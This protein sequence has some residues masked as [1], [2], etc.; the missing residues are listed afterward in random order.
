MNTTTEKAMP[1]RQVQQ[2]IMKQKS[3]VK[4]VR[5]A[6]EVIEGMMVSHARPGD[7][8]QDDG[9]GRRTIASSQSESS[10][11]QQYKQPDRPGKNKER[12]S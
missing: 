8:C 4:K 9:R 5:E 11:N 3:F 6:Y 12:Y 7:A 2:R 10:T 1:A